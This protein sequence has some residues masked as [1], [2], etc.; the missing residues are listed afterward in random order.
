[1]TYPAVNQNSERS[2]VATRAFTLIE[3]LV[4]IAIIAILAGMLL[5]ALAKAKK[6]AQQIHCTS[7]LKQMA[8]AIHMYTDD[9]TEYLPGELWTGVFFTYRRDTRWSLAYHLTPYLGI[10]A[11]NNLIQTAMVTRCPASLKAFPK[12][13]S[14]PNSDPLRV[15]LSY[16]SNATLTN[17]TPTLMYPFGRP[18]GDY[19]ASKRITTI[20]NPSD[21][22]A[23]TDADQ[24]NV[25]SL[26]TYYQF[27]P[28]RPVHGS[29]KPALRTYMYFDWSVRVGKTPI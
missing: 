3:L 2:S 23:M 26:A 8:L 18:S 14:N 9:N 6:K 1:M 4:V 17:Q 11:P 10:P 12:M 25:P 22:W 29:A 24:Q 19:A 21:S 7:N 16:F 13:A 20:Q 15:P 27:V 5:P 28:K